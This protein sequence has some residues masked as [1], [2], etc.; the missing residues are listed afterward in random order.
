VRQF[1]SSGEIDNEP[2]CG[3]NNKVSMNHNPGIT[4]NALAPPVLDYD[5]LTASAPAEHY[6]TCSKENPLTSCGTVDKGR[7]R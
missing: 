5:A 4:D 1:L 7:I 6:S 2:Y 3:I